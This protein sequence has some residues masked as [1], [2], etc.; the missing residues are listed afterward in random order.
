MSTQAAH[1]L[2]APTQW[3]YW[4]ALL[5]AAL[6]ATLVPWYLGVVDVDV[7]PSLRALLT[8]GALA[9]MLM[10]LDLARRGELGAAVPHVLGVAV[11]GACWYWLGAFD[12][13]AFLILFA[14][15][16][17]AVALECGRWTVLG[18]ATLTV[19]VATAAALSTS[20]ELRWQLAQLEAFAAV[21]PVD[22]DALRFAS[23]AAARQHLATLAV[24][25]VTILAVAAVG[26]SAAGVIRRQARTLQ[27]A[28][29]AQSEQALLVTKLLD[30]SSAMEVIVFSSSGRIHSANR[31]FHELLGDADSGRDL[32]ATLQPKYP[33][34]L[35]KLLAAADGG[36][37]RAQVCRPSTGEW[38]VDIDVEP[39][40]LDDGAMCRVR[41]RRTP[42]NDLV[43]V[44]LDALG[45]AVLILGP[46]RTVIFA[47]GAFRALFPHAADT[48]AA[49]AALD[50]RYALPLGWWD[51][52]PSKTAHVQFEHE[53]L[54]WRATLALTGAHG[55]DSLTS[56][57]LHA[58]EPA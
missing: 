9:L 42:A 22:G 11:L 35:Q 55:D 7:R 49:A 8:G 28:D 20:P 41:L 15:P 58:E 37:L 46:D 36:A 23:S 14:V 52:A 31:A 17:Y 4:A 18:V 40:V 26:T 43:T 56:I 25:A 19:L 39:V 13:A 53:G 30:E 1:A 54:R 6:A 29:R 24:F 12:V 27:R 10:Q 2:P 21:M 45:L 16:T 57:E 38:L 3:S 5:G 32:F 34:P 51:I 44:A 33:E 50:D 48:A 47:S